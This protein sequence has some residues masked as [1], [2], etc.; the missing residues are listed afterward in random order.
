[1]VGISVYKY[2]DILAKTSQ[3]FGDMVSALQSGNDKML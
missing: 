2:G 3:F 1:M